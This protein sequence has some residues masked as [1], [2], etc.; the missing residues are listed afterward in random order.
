MANMMKMLLCDIAIARTLSHAGLKIMET[1][2]AETV[3]N[4]HSTANTWLDWNR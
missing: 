1:R 3:D 4:A 2:M